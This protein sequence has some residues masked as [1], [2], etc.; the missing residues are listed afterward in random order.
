MKP[1]D[2]IHIA[3]SSEAIYLLFNLQLPQILKI[4]F[5]SIHP[6]QNYI[7]ENKRKQVYYFENKTKNL[8]LQ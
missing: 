7:L 4:Y 3:F 1:Y 8:T 5:V 6:D 2:S